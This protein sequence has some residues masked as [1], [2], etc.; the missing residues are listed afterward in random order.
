MT[1]RLSIKANKTE[2]QEQGDLAMQARGEAHLKL[3]QT[4]MRSLGLLF[5]SLPTLFVLK[6]ML[7]SE[8]A[9]EALFSG[10]FLFPAATVS[11][12]LAI[13]SSVLADRYQR[14][15]ERLIYAAQC[16][17]EKRQIEMEIE[18]LRAVEAYQN[19]SSG[20]PSTTEGSHVPAG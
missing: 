15:G 19:K 18:K 14:K 6:A 3:A 2:N 11:S 10:D 8:Q 4:I 13:L 9:I 1:V 16:M 12:V 5:V 17:E 7:E 20:G